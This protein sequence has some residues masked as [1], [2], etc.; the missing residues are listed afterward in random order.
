MQTIV[1]RTILHTL[2]FLQFYVYIHKKNIPYFS[3]SLKSR[4]GNIQYFNKSAFLNL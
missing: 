1:A 2:F 3:D 4:L